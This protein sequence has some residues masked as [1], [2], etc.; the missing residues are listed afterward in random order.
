MTEIEIRAKVEQLKTSD[1]P[2]H[3]KQ[4][5]IQELEKSLPDN[6]DVIRKQIQ[7]SK[8]DIDSADHLN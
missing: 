5:A 3:V 4:L 1:A 6:L 7:E 8:S 2:Y